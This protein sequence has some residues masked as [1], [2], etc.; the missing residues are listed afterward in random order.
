MSG[1]TVEIWS[2]VACPFC[3]IGKRNFEQALG[4]FEHRDDVEVIWRS[5]QLGPQM[6]K[7]TSGDIF[8]VLAAKYGGTR[9]Q[10]IE[11]N[12]RVDGMAREAGLDCDFPAIKPTNT[13]DAHRLVHLASF[14]GLQDE[15]KERLF[16]AYF[17]DGENVSDPETLTRVGVEIGLDGDD[18][19]ALLGSDAFATEVEAEHEQAVEFGISGVPTFVFDR[20][21]GISGAQPSEILLEALRTAWAASASPAT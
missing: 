8:D 18:I 21:S 5:F 6:P 4:Q 14:S 16:K 9:E 12:S 10:A 7:Q 17:I 13:R 19:S 11:M 2:D 3:Y 1:L 15:A 20:K